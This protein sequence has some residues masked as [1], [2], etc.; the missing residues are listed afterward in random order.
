MRTWSR[1]LLYVICIFLIKVPKTSGTVLIL[2]VVPQPDEDLIQISFA[3]N[4]YLSHKSPQGARHL[5]GSLPW[6]WAWFCIRFHLLVSFSFCLKL[7]EAV[8]G[9]LAGKIHFIF[10]LHNNNQRPAHRSTV[11]ICCLKNPECCTFSTSP[12]FCW[13]QNPFQGRTKTLSWCISQRLRFRDHIE[14]FWLGDQHWTK[15]TKRTP[16]TSNSHSHSNA[17]ST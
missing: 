6:W 15:M 7:F 14:T 10:H 2:H 13:L 16:A 12:Y 1:S 17:C 8:H 4:L 11:S 5:A 9:S 3:C